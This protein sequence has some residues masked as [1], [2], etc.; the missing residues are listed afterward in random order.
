MAPVDY[1][2]LDYYVF[3]TGYGF[4]IC[5]INNVYAL[6]YLLDG[7]EYRVHSSKSYVSMAEAMRTKHL[8]GSPDSLFDDNC[9]IYL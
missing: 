2:P 6:R 3:V 9:C 4:E 7:G 8:E 5:S 1:D